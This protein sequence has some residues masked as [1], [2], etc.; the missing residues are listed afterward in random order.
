M[1]DWLVLAISVGCGL[2]VL[3]GLIAMITRRPLGV[4]HLAVAAVVEL[5]VLTQVVLA[6][7]GL[8]GGAEVEGLALFLA[9]LGFAVVVVPAGALWAVGE[10]NRWSGGVLAVAAL[11]LVVTLTRLSAVWIMPGA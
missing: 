8:I 2:L 5:A 7:I 4:G 9:Y 1:R 11:A 10:K 3:L 6:V